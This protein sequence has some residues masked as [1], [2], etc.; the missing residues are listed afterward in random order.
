MPGESLYTQGKRTGTAPAPA[1]MQAALGL[2]CTGYISEAEKELAR[3]RRS[4]SE[5]RKYLRWPHW[6]KFHGKAGRAGLYILDGR[7]GFAV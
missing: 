6:C 7:T 1:E 4:C 3:R 2:K 5:S